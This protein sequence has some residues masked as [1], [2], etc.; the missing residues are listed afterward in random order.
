M[1]KLKTFKENAKTF[2]ERAKTYLYLKAAGCEVEGGDHLIEVL[3][4]IIIAAFLL[5]LFRGKIAEIFN[6]AL[7]K[8]S[9]NLNNMF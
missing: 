9:T 8:T 3:G 7:N 1:G 2:K 6:N 4:T 5:F